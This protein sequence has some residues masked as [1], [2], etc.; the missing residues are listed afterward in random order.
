M[1]LFLYKVKSTLFFIKKI[2]EYRDFKITEYRDF[3]S[4]FIHN[5]CIES[6]FI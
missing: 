6:K 4:Y 2:T 5:I 1:A 3:Q